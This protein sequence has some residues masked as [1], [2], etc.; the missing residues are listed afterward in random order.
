MRVSG[1]VRSFLVIPRSMGRCGSTWFC[2]LLDG[3]PQ[4]SCVG[5]IFNPDLRKRW[6]PVLQAMRDPEDVAG[7]FGAL[8]A[9]SPA[10]SARGFKVFREHVGDD[11]LA[12]LVQFVDA[13][14][15]IHRE[16]LTAALA[17]D[18]HGRSSGTWHA[19]VDEPAPQDGD[20][21]AVHIDIDR[22]RAR[23]ELAKTT[24]RTVLELVMRTGKPCHEVVYE[25]LVDHQQETLDA[26]FAF[27]GL[28][29][30]AVES[31]YRKLHKSASFV[32]NLEEVNRELGPEYGMLPRP[33][34]EPPSNSEPDSE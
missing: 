28:P 2:N 13:V 24:E 9:R 19:T 25:A 26:A 29:P 31:G 18:F 8:A 3:H 7:L 15:L 1:T 10:V 17:S 27:L 6:E 30:H 32:A 21:H 11:R 4:V 20:T 12:R 16:N 34:A 5:E 22:A 33:E 14:V 23:L